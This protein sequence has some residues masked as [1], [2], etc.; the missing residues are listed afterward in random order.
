MSSSEK[1][2]FHISPAT[3]VATI[4]T[5]YFAKT[6]WD[7]MPRWIKKRINQDNGDNDTETAEDSDKNLTN[8]MVIFER[9]KMLFDVIDRKVSDV[10]PE[11]LPSH[12]IFAAAIGAI[13]LYCEIQATMPLEKENLYRE[14]AGGD[15]NQQDLDGLAQKME[16]A[17]WAYEDQRA[18]LDDKL[19]KVSYDLLRFDQATEPGRVGHYIAI[20]YDKKVVLIGLKGTSTFSDVLTDVVAH[21]SEYDLKNSFDSSYAEKEIRAHEG[22][23]AAAVLMADETQQLIENLFIPC[24][25]SIL[26]TG[27]SLGAGTACLLGLL[28]RTRIPALRNELKDM[29]KVYAFA[30]PPVLNYDAALACAPFVTSV[31]NNSDVIPRMSLSNL[32]VLNRL[33]MK[34]N[35]R[36]EEKGL[37]P[38][39]L[40][41]ALALAQDLMVIDDE[42]LLSCEELR[43]FYEETYK[44]EDMHGVDN[45]YVPGR[46][47]VL[48]PK[49]NEKVKEGEEK[50]NL[51]VKE[52]E[53]SGAAEKPF[54]AVVGDGGM[55]ML[56]CLELNSTLLT[57]HLADSYIGHLKAAATY[58]K[59]LDKN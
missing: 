33:L 42:L 15:A 22:I 53:D 57:D 43:D 39:D 50:E 10:I 36:Q 21:S 51:E 35:K 32:V 54:L 49:E 3:V 29:L 28:L 5:V 25:Y 31:V 26:I 40:K 37:S 38:D 18:D 13:H 58:S 45:L 8:P 11:H 1:L 9:I 34:V 46:V 20:N 7:G 48:F 2:G 14:A 52:S 19:K 55:K 59:L 17:D 16:F 41:T 23:F 12:K 27:H 6:L 47:I 44:S 24:K 30:P 56:R 4:L